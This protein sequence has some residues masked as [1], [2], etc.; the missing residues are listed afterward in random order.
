MLV[1]SR[2]TICELLKEVEESPLGLD[3][4]LNVSFEAER[5]VKFYTEIGSCL[6]RME[7]DR[8]HSD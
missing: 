3:Q 5:A 6:D 7:D 2:S 8:S 4:V 1:Y